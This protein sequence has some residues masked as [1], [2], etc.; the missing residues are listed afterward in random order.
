MRKIYLNL[1]CSIKMDLKQLFTYGFYQLSLVFSSTNHQNYA[2]MTLSSL[3]KF[4]LQLLFTSSNNLVDRPIFKKKIVK[5]HRLLLPNVII[6][7]C[8]IDM[9]LRYIKIDTFSWKDP[10]DKKI[11][12]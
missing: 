3:V 8:Q 11:K 1:H 5:F 4:S 6:W 9:C 12:A 10:S 2:R 7:K